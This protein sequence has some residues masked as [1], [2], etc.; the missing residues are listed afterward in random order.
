MA[1]PSCKE[2]VR[3][4]KTPVLVSD[5]ISHGGCALMKLADPSRLTTT[6]WPGKHCAHAHG[7]AAS[8]VG[9]AGDSAQ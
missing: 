1:G 6:V 7:Q 5:L 2:Q 3:S 8:L 9:L 4:G